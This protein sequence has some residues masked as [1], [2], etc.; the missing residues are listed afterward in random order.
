M[1]EWDDEKNRTN[2]LKHDVSFETAAL[3]FGDPY[4]LTQRDR[5]SNEERFVTLGAIGS[6]GAVRGTCEL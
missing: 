1:F 6:G 3:V 4:S 2:I 5:T